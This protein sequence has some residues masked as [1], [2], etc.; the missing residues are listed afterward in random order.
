MRDTRQFVLKT[1]LSVG[2]SLLVLALILRFPLGGDGAVRPQL[3]RILHETIPTAIGLYFLLSLAQA[4]FRALRYR[5]L[6]RAAGED[7]VPSA[8]HTL[9]VTLARNMFVDL[10]P[11]RTG[12]LTYIAMM[13]RGHHVSGKACVSSLTI[14]FLFD[15]I[16]MI[17]LLAILIGYQLLTFHVQGWLLF[18]L[19]ALVVMVSVMTIL[20]F[21]GI[22]TCMAIARRILGNVAAKPA[23]ARVL[24]FVD[25]VAETVDFTR[26]S[27]TLLQTLLLSLCVRL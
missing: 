15:S 24:G 17:V 5:L 23:V 18:A 19:V 16:G 12:E 11:A 2:V 10:L 13:N 6:I 7:P 20:L 4:L 25:G 3:L 1:A 14:S 27:G 26:R 8:G 9:F 22:R 21:A